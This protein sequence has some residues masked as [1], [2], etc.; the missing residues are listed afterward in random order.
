MF[1]TDP[2]ILLDTMLA[3]GCIMGAIM[4]FL[5]FVGYCIGDKKDK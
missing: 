4:V 2:I 1:A 3:T 5:I